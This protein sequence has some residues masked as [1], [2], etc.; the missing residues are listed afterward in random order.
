MLNNMEEG[1]TMGIR[2]SAKAV[3]IDKGQ[4]LVNKHINTLGEMY[5]GLPDGAEYYD[6]PGGGQHQYETLE[7]AVTRECLEETGY[8]VKVERLLAV[9][10]EISLNK[11]FRSYYEQY[12]HVLYFVFLCSLKDTERQPY[13]ELDIDMVEA[14]WVDI[15]KISEMPVYPR[16]IGSSLISLLESENPQFLGSDYAD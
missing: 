12:A 5:Y 11:D 4:V 2:N 10:E 16:I 15:N 8:N 3:I 13:T 7:Q 6:L 9:Y 1:L 14:Q